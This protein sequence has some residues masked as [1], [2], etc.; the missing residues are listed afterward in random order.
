MSSRSVS[1]WSLKRGDQEITWPGEWEFFLNEPLEKKWSSRMNWRSLSPG[2]GDWL[3]DSWV[4]LACLAALGWAPTNV[5]FEWASGPLSNKPP[6]WL[7]SSFHEYHHHHHDNHFASS[8]CISLI[9]W[10]NV[11][12]LFQMSSSWP[13]FSYFSLFK[14]LTI[15]A[16]LC[17]S[18]AFTLTLL[19]RA[20]NHAY[21]DQSQLY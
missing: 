7:W 9:N 18:S 6:V 16:F 14:W 11:K 20:H 8:L 2:S 4:H 5:P 10:E 12:M 3:S 1:N 17:E 15:L 13:F 21:L 19:V